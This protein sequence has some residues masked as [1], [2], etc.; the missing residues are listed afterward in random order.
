MAC[1][2]PDGY[3]GND[4]DCDDSLGSVRPGGVEVCDRP[5]EGVMPLDED[6]DGEANPDALC[7]C[8]VPDSRSCADGGLQGACGGGSQDCVDGGWGACSISA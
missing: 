1:F 5:A 7:N 4:D 2:T 6:C 8:T 3:A